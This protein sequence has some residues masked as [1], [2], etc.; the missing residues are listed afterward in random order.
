MI[1]LYKIYLLKNLF[2]KI[3]IFFIFAEF[4]SVEQERVQSS[5]K[6]VSDVE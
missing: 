4:A 2:L 6:Y 3:V 5:D 1:V